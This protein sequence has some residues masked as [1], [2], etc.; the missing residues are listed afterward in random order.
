[1]ATIPFYD[2]GSF[3]KPAAIDRLLK[4]QKILTNGNMATK[5]LYLKAKLMANDFWIPISFSN[6]KTAKNLNT[7]LEACYQ[8]HV[9]T[10]KYLGDFYLE[11]LYLPKSTEISLIFTQSVQQK[12][13][14]KAQRY[15][16]NRAIEESLVYF[17]KNLSLKKRM[18]I[19]IPEP[20][21]AE[22][23]TQFKI[24]ARKLWK[25]FLSQNRGLSTTYGTLYLEGEWKRTLRKQA[26]SINVSTEYFPYLWHSI[27]LN[28]IDE[29]WQV[30]FNVHEPHSKQGKIAERRLK[31]DKKE[32][33]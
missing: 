4:I 19:F 22:S 21:P 3:T 15:S 27:T 26:E 24:E 5:F 16:L 17:R 29:S 6:E 18:E 11:H 1:M 28:K 9:W 13:W 30:K 14:L 2:L 32:Y 12:R 23:Y 31:R 8:T 20:I 7:G 10:V 25:K 33:A